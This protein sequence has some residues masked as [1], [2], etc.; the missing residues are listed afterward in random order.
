MVTQY[1]VDENIRT[2]G[3]QEHPNDV[4]KSYGK[5]L[6]YESAASI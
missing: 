4:P 2:L 5:S 1:E 6:S 3:Q